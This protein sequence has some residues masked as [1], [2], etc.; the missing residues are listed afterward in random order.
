MAASQCDCG[1]GCIGSSVSI[2]P[3][4]SAPLLNPLRIWQNGMPNAPVARLRRWKRWRSLSVGMRGRG[5]RGGWVWLGPAAHLPAQQREQLHTLLTR[6][7]ELTPIYQLAQRFM[8]LLQQRDE[9]AVLPR[10]E[11]AERCS[12]SQVR[13]LAHGLRQDLPRERR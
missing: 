3:V 1:G 6:S 4:V 11:E 8:H 2:E 5:W 13:T 7:S 12:W 9:T 10:V